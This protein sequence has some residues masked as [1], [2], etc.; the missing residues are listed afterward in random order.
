MVR[1]SQ[2]VSEISYFRVRLAFIK[3][4]IFCSAKSMDCFT[5]KRHHS[6]ENENNRKATESFAPRLLIF[7]F[8]QDVLKFND[9]CLSCS[10]PKTDMETFLTYEIE[11]LS[12]SLFRN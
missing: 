10:S 4:Y 2:S 1:F 6:F 11:V 3:T 8:Q 9:I 5:L 12:M 7:K